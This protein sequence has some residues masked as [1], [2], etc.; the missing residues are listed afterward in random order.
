MQELEIKILEID[1]P[2]TL[3]IL[4]GIGAVKSF[5]SDILADF[6]V[7]ERKDK[8]RLRRSNGQNV[9]AFKRKLEA[10]GIMHNEEYEVSFDDYESMRNILL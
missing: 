2:K 5:D 6:F 4:E 7:N 3:R 8:I 1:V 9:M 10:N